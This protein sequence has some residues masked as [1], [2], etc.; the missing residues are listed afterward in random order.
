VCD[1]KRKAVDLPILYQDN[2]F[3]VV[4]KRS[5]L[6]VHRSGLDRHA[7]EFALQIVRDQLGKFV[8]PVHR[9]DRATSGALVFAFSKENAKTMAEQFSSRLVQKTYLAVVRGIPPGKIVIDYPL[10]EELDAITDKKARIDKGPQ[11]AITEVE[12]LASVEFPV[13]VD[14]YPTSRYALVRAKPKTGRKHQIRRH[15]RH[16]GHPLI[17]DITH[18]SGKH[19]RFFESRFGLRRLLLA[20]TEISFAHPRTGEPIFVKAPLAA[21]FKDLL[22]QIGWTEHV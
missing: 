12:T 14:K 3:V 21:D 15:L 18:G 4:N 22:T 17:G 13:Q 6:L 19:N 1:L 8:F 10:K 11:A 16:L 2:E 7:T 5:G 9:L 20:C